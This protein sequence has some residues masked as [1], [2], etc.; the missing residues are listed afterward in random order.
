[1]K[2]SVYILSLF[3]VNRLWLPTSFTAMQRPFMS[4]LL[5]L[6]TL[7]SSSTPFQIHWG[8][9]PLGLRTY[10][11]PHGMLFVHGCFTSLERSSVTTLFK[12]ID[13]PT[14]RAHSTLSYNLCLFRILITNWH[15]ILC[16][17]LLFL[18]TRMETP[19]GQDFFLLYS[20]L[21]SLHVEHCP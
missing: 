21:R 20:L 5:L 6:R 13:L 8:C 11:T 4:W 19:C 3:F 18:L 9:L 12:F 15:N 2:K 1:M 10:V 14:T 17:I 16:Y 7:T